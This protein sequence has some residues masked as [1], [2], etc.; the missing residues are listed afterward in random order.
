M[1]TVRVIWL[2]VF[3]LAFVAS[4]HAVER[5]QVDRFRVTANPAPQTYTLAKP[6]APATELLV[7]RN[8]VLMSAGDDYTRAGQSVAFTASQPIQG[9]SAPGAAD[10]DLIVFVYFTPVT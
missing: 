7:F 9:D 2:A 10:G 4:L 5:M 3:A 6:V 1:K 8:G